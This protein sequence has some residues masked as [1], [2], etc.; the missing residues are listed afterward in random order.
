MS[1]HPPEE[2]SRE[3]EQCTQCGNRQG[4]LR[5][6]RQLAGANEHEALDGFSEGNLRKQD[7]GAGLGDGATRV[8]SGQGCVEL[9]LRS[10]PGQNSDGFLEIATH[11]PIIMSTPSMLHST[12]HPA[13]RPSLNRPRREGFDRKYSS[14][15]NASVVV[16]GCR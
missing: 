1:L 11:S 13:D 3:K 7:L 8:P 4:A 15:F 9:N 5:S 6:G 2:A 16:L 14:S 10:H 12:Q